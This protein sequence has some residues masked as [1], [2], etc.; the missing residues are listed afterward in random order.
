[1]RPQVLYPLFAPARSLPGVGPRLAA[2]VEKLAGPRVVDLLW[3]LPSGLIDRRFSPKVAA[4][5]PGTVAD[6]DR[7]DPRSSTVGKLAPALSG[8][9]RGRYRRTGTGVLPC[10]RRLSGEGAA[11]RRAPRGQRRR[12]ALRPAITD[13]APG[14]HRR[15]SRTRRHCHRRAGLSADR[16]FDRQASG[17][18]GARGPSNERRNWWNGRTRPSMPGRAGNPGAPLWRTLMHRERRPIVADVS[19]A[20]PPRL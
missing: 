3:H 14:P 20:L 9:L 2:V 18:I 11:R 17:E 16:R 7:P 6:P 10:S 13:D 5:L 19:G 12:G 4:A 1:M 8:Y 15:R